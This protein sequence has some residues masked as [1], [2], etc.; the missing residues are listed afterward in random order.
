M[1]NGWTA[2]WTI[3]AAAA[4]GASGAKAQPAGG[5]APDD[6]A[7][8]EGRTDQPQGGTDAQ[9]GATA[10][11]DDAAWLAGGQTPEPE[12]APPAE[13]PYA[14]LREDPDQAYHLAGIRA[15]AAFL[16]SWLVEAFGLA[17]SPGVIGPAVGVEYTF[18]RRGLDIVPAVWWGGYITEG[19]V[20][21]ESDP[22]EDTE[23]VKSTVSVLWFTV[24]FLPSYD[25]NDWL[26]LVYGGGVGIGVRF[27]EIYRTEAYQR[28][29]GGWDR[30]ERAGTPSPVFCEEGGQYDYKQP[31]Q[32]KNF[33]WP[34]YPQFSGRFGLRFK[35]LR[36]LVIHTD[37]GVDLPLPPLFF[38]GGRINYMF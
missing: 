29:D 17:E 19:F 37:L 14:S 31:E 27:G 24:D 38:I 7:F 5:L 2:A 35:P 30:C 16:P 20:R 26:A 33:F 23:F 21:A 8:L 13:D 34:V 22:R 4:L 18:R 36:N 9:T 25:I 12:I 10:R 3:V 15:H 1:M 28:P 6:A 32:F 11:T